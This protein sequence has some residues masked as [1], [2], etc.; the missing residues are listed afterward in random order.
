[1]MFKNLDLTK[2]TYEELHLLLKMV[3]LYV[4]EH[5]FEVISSFEEAELKDYE[6]IITDEMSA[7]RHRNPNE[8]KQ[9]EDTRYQEDPE[10][11]VD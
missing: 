5:N 9:N 7:K 11:W 8:W 4:S 3:D 6:N 1:M 10:N 2:L